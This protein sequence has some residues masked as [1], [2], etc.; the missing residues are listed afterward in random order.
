[1]A[2]TDIAPQTKGARFT[3]LASICVVVA[4]LWFMQDVLIPLALSI[5]LTF[6]FTPIANRLERWKLGRVGS[7]LVITIT[8]L[9]LIVILGWVVGKQVLSLANDLDRY[10][11]NIRY[12]IKS[13]RSSGPTVT[14]KV[15]SAVE[16]IKE[17]FSKDTTT[18]PATTK[19]VVEAVA[20]KPPPELN[21]TKPATQR[22][23]LEDITEDNPLPVR[24]IPQ[25]PTPMEDLGSYAGKFIGPIGTLGW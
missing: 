23:G 13:V 15:A 8:T 24:E 7:V 4:G 2:R 11:A 9:A 17:E 21:P 6:L 22:A 10:Q 5:L 12:K 3:L 19:A 25:R 18:Q 20:G 14:S 1:M 16:G